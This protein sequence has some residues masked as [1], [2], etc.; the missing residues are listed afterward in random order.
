MPRDAR[1]YITLPLD[2]H[3]HPKLR[4]QPA[5]V[6]WAFVEMNL[7]AR[8]AEN[9]GRFSAEDAEFLWPP[10]ILAALVRTHPSRPVVVRDGTDYVIREYGEHQLTKAD[11]DDLRAKRAEAGRKGG[12]SRAS[13]KQVLSTSEQTEAESESEDFSKT[14]Q[15]QSSSERASVSTDSVEASAMT[16]RLASQAGITSLQAV[17]DATRKHAHRDITPDGAFRLCV[18]VLAKARQ[19]PRNPQMYVTR[20]ISLSAFE[21]QQFVDEQGLAS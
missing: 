1:L 3:R 17:V 9:D 12:K 21:V 8:L 15:S 10:E 2:I 13:A 5:E 11:R 4:D 18:H 20:S 19:H 14:S 6:K 7:E 16:K